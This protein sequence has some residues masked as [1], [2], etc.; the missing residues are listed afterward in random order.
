MQITHSLDVL[1]LPQNTIETTA[2]LQC[3]SAG[4]TTEQ[5]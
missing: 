3:P 1:P 4:I 5:R 2:N